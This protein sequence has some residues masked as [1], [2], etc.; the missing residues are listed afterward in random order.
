MRLI[1]TVPLVL[2]AQ[3]AK[4]GLGP[5]MEVLANQVRERRFALDKMALDNPRGFARLFRSPHFWDGFWT[6]LSF[7]ALFNNRARDTHRYATKPA[8]GLSASFHQVG[9]DYRCAILMLMDARKLTPDAL[10]LN[11]TDMQDLNL[12]FSSTYRGGRDY[13]LIRSQG[14][15]NSLKPSPKAA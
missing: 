3:V 6:V 9:N 4:A 12:C 13:A 11:P 8:N 2:M 10:G 15:K 14:I 7:G 1:E 5:E